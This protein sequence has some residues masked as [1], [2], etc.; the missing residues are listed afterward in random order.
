[1]NKP[2]WRKISKRL[3]DGRDFAKVKRWYKKSVHRKNRRKN[4]QDPLSIDKQLDTW[5]ID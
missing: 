3:G 5:D 4:K 2:S 1:M